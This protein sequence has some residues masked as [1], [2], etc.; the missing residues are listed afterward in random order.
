MSGR[1]A[2]ECS[3]QEPKQAH[4]NPFAGLNQ[5]K[6]SQSGTYLTDGRYK[7][8]I[9]KCV[10]F[11]T[12]A[13]PYAFIAEMVVTET[14]DAAAH[15]VGAAR[16]WYQADNESFKP[17]LKGFYYAATGYNHTDPAQEKFIKDNIEQ[18]SESLM[19]KAVT[20][21]VL[22]GREVSVDVT[23]KKQKK[24]PT[25]D[26]AKH[27]FAPASPPIPVEYLDKAIALT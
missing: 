21:Q 7:L 8:K 16:T 10:Y 12:Q 14:S 17:E 3:Y 22:T 20:H 2:A 25:K 13:G 24:D 23:T 18:R 4:M 15:P 27:V 26:F 1:D 9:N 5:A 19:Q 11:K 6:T